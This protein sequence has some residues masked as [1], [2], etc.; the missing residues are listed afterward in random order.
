MGGSTVLKRFRV[1]FTANV[2]LYHVT[3]FSHYLLL[4]VHYFCKT[5]KNFYVI[6]IHK[7]C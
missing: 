6:F 4:T 7:N 1:T 3:K 2:N 5:F